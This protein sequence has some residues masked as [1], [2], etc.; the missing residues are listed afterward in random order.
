MQINAKGAQELS[1]GARM[2]AALATLTKRYDE[3]FN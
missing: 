2:R 3:I 1:V